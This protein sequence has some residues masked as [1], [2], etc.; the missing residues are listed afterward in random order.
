MKVEELN[1]EIDKILTLSTAHITK[2][3]SEWL[4]SEYQRK[5]NYPLIV[6]D[7]EYGWVI[8][9]LSEGESPLYN[10]IPPDLAVLYHWC[11]EYKI[12][13]LRLDQDGDTS[14]LFPTFE[15]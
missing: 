1:L 10:D 6:Y 11:F 4:S 13:F 15:W 9:I 7:Y 14:D 12:G 2:E 5:A 3:T 8:V